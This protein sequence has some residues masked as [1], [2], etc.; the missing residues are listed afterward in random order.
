MIL[1]KR[2]SSIAAFTLIELLVVIAI[3]A[4]LAGM[5]L[6]ALSKAKKKGQ[7]AVCAAHQKQ[8]SLALLMYSD[9]NRQIFPPIQDWN[10]EPSREGGWSWRPYLFD[11]V[12]RSV[13]VYDCPSEK[14]D[15]YANGEP[16]IRGE[17]VTGEIL[18]PSGIGAAN[19]HFNQGGAPSAFGEPRYWGGGSV[20][21]KESS[22]QAAAQMITFGDGHSDYEGAWPEYRW[23]IWKDDDTNG[24]GFNRLEQTDPGTDRHGIGA[25][26][27]FG[28]GHVSLLKANKIPCDR[29]ACW[30]S[31]QLNPHQDQ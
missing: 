5:L 12:S 16:G 26:Y 10:G 3:I 28:D 21:L 6:P 23:W 11:Y 17:F 27:S 30:W 1:N 31:S 25:N 22:L 18:I 29:Q 13:G 14:K 7:Q 24:P 2:S 20:I 19:V 9:D 8:L 15:R 4:I